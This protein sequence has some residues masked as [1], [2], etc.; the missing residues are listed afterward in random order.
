MTQEQNTS[1]LSIT[2]NMS[3]KLNA[4]WS[5]L[6]TG[7]NPRGSSTEDNQQDQMI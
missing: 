2:V 3:H 1:Y 6:N 4:D 7:L 5:V